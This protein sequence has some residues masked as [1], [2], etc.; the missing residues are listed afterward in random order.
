ML[1]KGSTTIMIDRPSVMICVP[2]SDTVK[3]K[4]FTSCMG[5]ALE[6]QKYGVDIGVLNEQCS[7]ISLARNR[8]T[9]MVLSMEPRYTHILWIDSDMEAP[10]TALLQLL[11]HDKD[12]C[13]AFYNQRTPPFH[14]IGCVVD[15]SID[16]SKGGVHRASEMPGG[17]VLIKTDVYRA[18]QSP[19]YF[20]SHDPARKWDGDPDGTI[21]EDYNFSYKAA[22]GGYEMWVDLDLTFQMRHIGS[23]SVP[24]VRP[25]PT[26]TSPGFVFRKVA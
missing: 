13:C 2:S 10:S 12:I 7:I 18:L 6:S 24:C 11:S 9:H 16:A 1:G 14:T 21:G 5:L 22:A 20:E 17:F 4:T 26:S 23:L 25:D 19:W 8:M 3:A 15:T